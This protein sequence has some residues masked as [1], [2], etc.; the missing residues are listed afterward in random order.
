M[1]VSEDQSTKLMILER[2]IGNSKESKDIRN[3]YL[4]MIMQ[5]EGVDKK[6]LKSKPYLGKLTKL[7]SVYADQ[8]KWHPAHMEKLVKVE[9]VVE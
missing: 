6:K 3:T 2:L 5:P 7:D 9:N 1:D 4:R 8:V